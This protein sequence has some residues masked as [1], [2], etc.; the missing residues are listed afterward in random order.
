[1]SDET[2]TVKDPYFV[3]F[4][5][6][7]NQAE[8]HIGGPDDTGLPVYGILV[9]DLIRH[10]AIAHGVEVEAVMAHVM[11]EL[12]RPSAVITRKLDA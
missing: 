4:R 7:A 9:A 2:Y 12:A 5:N 3:M 6:E 1:M 11:L 10:L 8:C